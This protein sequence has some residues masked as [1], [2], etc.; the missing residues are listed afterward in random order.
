MYNKQF[1]L[2]VCFYLFGVSTVLPQVFKNS[3]L[4]ISKQE[5]HTWL[6][7][8]TDMTSMYLIEGSKKALLIDTGTK[9][10]SLDT[11]IR[12][13]TKK[14]L[15][16]VITH[17]HGDHDGNIGFF[18]EIYMHP[19]DTVLFHNHYKGKVHFVTDGE[20]F[21]L[22]GKKIE[23]CHMPAHTPGSII[24]LDRE[25]GSCYTGDAFGSGQVWL[26]L[27]PVAPMKTY[28][29]SCSKMIDI[30]DKGI[31]K[32][33]CGHYPYAKGALDKEYIVRM[34]Q[35]AISIDEG[36]VKD[37]QPYSTKVSIGPENPMIAMDGN[38]GIVYDPGHIK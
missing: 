28:I 21:D 4:Q 23:V 19:A 24:L 18:D 34:K 36:T 14:P 9:C 8:T 2:S 12:K 25:A 16:V 31:A 7:E 10:D 20:V 11:I 13:I 15:T 27:R 30:M 32:I 6:I 1:L 26:Q 33:Y 5:D 22:G 38:V 37:S 29:S 3:D 35:I 17:A